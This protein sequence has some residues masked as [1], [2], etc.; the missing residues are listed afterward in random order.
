[1]EALGSSETSVLTR[2]T[3]RKISEDAFLH[4]HRRENLK[5]YNI[6]GIAEGRLEEQP[7]TCIKTKHFD[8]QHSMR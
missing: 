3:R 1:M 6:L 4:S 2:P 8:R 5:S 7:T